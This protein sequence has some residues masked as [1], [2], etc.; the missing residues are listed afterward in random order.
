MARARPGTPDDVP[1]L[2]RL[3]DGDGAGVPGLIL[4][5]GGFRHGVLLA[6]LLADAAAALVTGDSPGT[7]LAGVLRATDP[8]RFHTTD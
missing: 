5:T 3:R 8:Y 4:A 1:L 7:D 2:G 6:P